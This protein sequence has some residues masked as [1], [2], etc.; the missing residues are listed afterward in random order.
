MDSYGASGPWY[1]NHGVSGSGG[2]QFPTGSNTPSFGVNV[3]QQHTVS[4]RPPVPVPTSGGVEQV[5]S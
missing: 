2:Y 4:P 3:F 1:F 5:C